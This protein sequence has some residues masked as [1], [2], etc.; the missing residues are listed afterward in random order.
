MNRTIL[1][2]LKPLI[3]ISIVFWTSS[4]SKPE[5]EPL[6]VSMFELL[7]FP[8]RFHEQRIITVGYYHEGVPTALY[9]YKEDKLYRRT[10]RSAQALFAALNPV[11]SFSQCSG[12]YIQ[13]EGYVIAHSVILG[14]NIEPQFM[15][16]VE[17]KKISTDSTNGDVLLD[18]CYSASA[19]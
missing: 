11:G 19:Q 1:K 3:V 14:G 2:L 8:E 17:I 13:I 5:N 12:N 10:P 4:C 16:A 7:I 15:K 9:P 6:R 18:T